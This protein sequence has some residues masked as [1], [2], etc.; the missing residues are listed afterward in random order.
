MKTSPKLTLTLAGLLLLAAPLLRAAA[1]PAGPPPGDKPRH[2]GRG[3][4]AMMERAA[5][6]LNLT[7][8]QDAKWKEINKQ[9]RA[10]LEPLRDDASLS[11]EDRRAK[12]MEINKGFAA[13]RRALLNP[14]QQAKFD[15]LRTKMREH[16]GGGPGGGPGDQPGQSG[17]PPAKQG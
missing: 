12:A 6:E 8:D 15:E 11:R 17:E 9:E 1:E 3:P 16:R 4:G 13:Q 10:A 5:K 7:P 2:E 14:E